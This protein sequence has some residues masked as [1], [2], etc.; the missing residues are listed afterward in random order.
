MSTT[1]TLP[2][3]PQNGCLERLSSFA[4]HPTRCQVVAADAT[5]GDPLQQAEALVLVAQGLDAACRDT[6]LGEHLKKS[7][8]ME[9]TPWLSNASKQLTVLFLED[10]KGAQEQLVV[11]QRKVEAMKLP[12]VNEEEAFRKAGVQAVSQLAQ[13]AAGGEKAKKK[14]RDCRQAFKALGGVSFGKAGGPASELQAWEKRHGHSPLSAPEAE[15]ASCQVVA[16]A[17]FQ[18]SAVAA[19]CSVRSEQ[20][21]AKESKALKNLAD[22][23]AT[24]KDRWEALQ[25][26]PLK[27]A[28]SSLLQTCQDTLQASNFKAPK[29]S[30]KGNGEQAP[31]KPNKTAAA[32]GLVAAEKGGQGKGERADAGTEPAEAESQ[33]VSKEEKK[34]KD[35]SDKKKE[36]KEAKKEKASKKEKKEKSQDKQGKKAKQEKTKDESEP[37]KDK[38]KKGEDE[39]VLAESPS[40]RRLKEVHEK[41]SAAVK[42]K[43]KAKAKAAAKALAQEPEPIEAALTG[44][45]RLAGTGGRGRG[46][47]RQGTGAP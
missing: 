1:R 47:G 4:V 36:K 6:A 10:L 15:R 27:Q 41:A 18:V 28:G 8:L 20:V 30:K 12:L 9:A 29:Q 24:L 3:Q 2:L 32:P 43:A 17:S 21:E 13:L 31:E 37:K 23:T 19:L 16:S 45:R 22:V 11:A 40:K 33:K 42:A 46:R 25:D 34:K 39:G 38:K 44:S 14:L 26:G 35:K 5:K 7:T